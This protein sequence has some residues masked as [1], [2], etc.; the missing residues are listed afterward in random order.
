MWSNPISM[1]ANQSLQESAGFSVGGLYLSPSA[2]IA[3]L[4]Q[5][6]T[7]T[8]DDQS[9]H[10]ELV[11]QLCDSAAESQAG[12]SCRSLLAVGNT[13]SVLQGLREKEKRKPTAFSQKQSGLSG[14]GRVLT[15]PELHHPPALG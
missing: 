7:A 10:T 12:K 8:R 1:K 15:Q 4:F 6:H 9:H 3:G 13:P 2:L 5:S 14:Q 11:L